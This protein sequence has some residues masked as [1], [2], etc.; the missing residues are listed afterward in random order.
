MKAKN[1]PTNLA[2][3]LAE[4]R[5]RLFWCSSALLL[6]TGLGFSMQDRLLDI[7]QAPLNHVLYYTSPA[8]GFGFVFKVALSFGFVL[9]LPIIMYHIVK[10]ISPAFSFKKRTIVFFLFS[11]AILALGGA[12]FAYFLSLPAALRFLTNFGGDNISALITADEYFNFALAYVLGFAA[13]F[14]LPLIISITDRI[15]PLTPRKMMGAQRYLILGSFIIAAILTPTPDPMNQALMAAP[16]VVLYQLAIVWIWIKSIARP[17]SAKRP[18]AVT[19]EAPAVTL[20]PVRPV[21]A[22]HKPVV[23]AAQSIPKPVQAPAHIVPS[24]QVIPVGAA[25]RPAAVPFVSRRAMDIMAPSSAIR[26]QAAATQ[27]TVPQHRTAPAARRDLSF[28]FL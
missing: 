25:V 23:T 14:Q 12:A 27:H 20:K 11:S 13:L 24:P 3:H 28:D 15:Y 7:L 8:G 19:K 6:A 5:T 18:V 9:T 26:Q 4:L 1:Q 10:F 2:S 22:T 16:I 17:K 21:V